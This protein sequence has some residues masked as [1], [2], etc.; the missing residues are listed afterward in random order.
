MKVKLQLPFRRACLSLP[1]NCSPDVSILVFRSVR[2]YRTTDLKRAPRHMV[3][4]DILDEELGY[5]RES[6]S[7]STTLRT[8]FYQACHCHRSL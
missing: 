4:P 3:T 6:Q 7:A 5:L 2:R 1:E 8:D